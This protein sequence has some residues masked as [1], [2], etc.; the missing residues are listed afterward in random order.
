MSEALEL[1]REEKGREGETVY[2]PPAIIMST[3]SKR[4]K[5]QVRD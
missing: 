4:P 3:N 5:K 2:V 1:E